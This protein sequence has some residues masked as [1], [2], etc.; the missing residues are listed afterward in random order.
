MI[1]PGFCQGS[2]RDINYKIEVDVNNINY[3]ISGKG[4]YT[5][6]GK[7]LVYYMGARNDNTKLVDP[8]LKLPKGLSVIEDYAFYGCTEL[9]RFITPASVKHIGYQA[10][11]SCGQLVTVE[12][13]ENVTY[14]GEYAFDACAKLKTVRIGVEYIRACTL[15]NCSSLRALELSKNVKEMAGNAVSSNFGD[16]YKKFNSIRFAG[17]KDEWLEK[18]F[19]E[20]NFGGYIREV[21]CTDG[22]LF[23]NIEDEDD[24]E[25]DY[26]DD[27]N[28]DYRDYDDD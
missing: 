28:Y 20:W 17:T 9:K 24:E 8:E 18:P 1:R 2:D 12:V 7:T 6:D 19:A 21:I 10:F 22:T 11:G 15:N 26:Y 3:K 13:G 5:K 27:D 14:L 23:N 4:L 25:Y 16:C